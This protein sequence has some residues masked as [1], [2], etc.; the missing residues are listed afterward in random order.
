MIFTAD[1]QRYVSNRDWI[2][3]LGNVW[4]AAQGR[5]VRGDPE[6]LVIFEGGIDAD[7]VFI[8]SRRLRWALR[9]LG[10]LKSSPRL[11]KLLPA[12]AA[13]LIA[14]VHAATADVLARGVRILLDGDELIRDMSRLFGGKPGAAPVTEAAF[15]GAAYSFWLTAGRTAKKLRRGEL[16]VAKYRTDVL[17]KDVVRQ[18]IE[19]HAQSTK[20]ASDT[21]HD[22][23]FL[24]EWADPRAVAGLGGAFAHYD[25]DDVWR[26]LLATMDLFRWLA[27]E[28]AESLGYSYPREV[29]G[30]ITALVNHHKAGAAS[31]TPP[32]RS[33]TAH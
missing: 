27:T 3:G 4:V 11:T 9:L 33:S 12:E 26:A 14:E 25:V 29:D 2:E 19:W 8:S 15:L 5:T 13:S 6:W 10:L 28:T 24:E 21:W 7:F 16:W 17:L 31:R 18:M 1:V 23:H 20:G 22:G 30:R 32:R